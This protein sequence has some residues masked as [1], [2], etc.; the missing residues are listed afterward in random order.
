MWLEIWK[1]TF[2][3]RY[4]LAERKEKS[5]TELTVPMNFLMKNLNI[6]LVRLLMVYANGKK[7]SV[8]KIFE[9]IKAISKERKNEKL[10]I[11]NIIR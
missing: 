11:I 3:S 10:P 1:I 9:A 4:L 7:E 6:T 8:M 5:F 2:W